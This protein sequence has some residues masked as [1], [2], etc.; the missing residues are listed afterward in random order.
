MIE[1]NNIMNKL[2]KTT[3]KPYVLAADTDSNYVLVEPIVDTL[4]KPRQMERT[5]SNVVDVVE[6]FV[7]KGL[8]PL[9]DKKFL[10]LCSSLGAYE[11]KIYFKLECIGP[12]I[13]MLAKKKY[14]FD[15]LY[16]EGVRYKDPKIKVMGLEIVRSSTPKVVKEYLMK[17]LTLTLRGT[18]E[19]LQEHVGKVKQLFMTH[20][21]P[22]IAFPRGCNGLTT[23]ASN[24]SI[25]QKGTP[26]HVRG[27]LLHNHHLKRLELTDK[28]NVINE[29]EKIKYIALKMPNPIRENVFSFI[30]KIPEELGIIRYIDKET[31]YQKAFLS[32]LKSILD[33]IGWE[34]EHR[35]TFD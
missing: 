31:Q 32:P 17:G 8:Q 28:Y 19:Q 16:S 33:V 30:G 9:L 24:S 27:A 4:L 34:P 6:E 22:D 18:E 21:Y 26:M 20:D 23:Y 11:K 14:A 25:Y 1:M 10:S 13:V 2:A 29:G 12:S 3:N 35:L 7:Q 15:I 5:P